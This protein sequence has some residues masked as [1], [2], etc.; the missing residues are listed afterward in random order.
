M[1][2]LI[3]AA[4]MGHFEVT[5]VLI[6][7]GASIEA[8]DRVSKILSIFSYICVCVCREDYSSII[9][10]DM[11]MSLLWIIHYNDDNSFGVCFND[12]Y[13]SASFISY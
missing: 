6:D 2:A 9:L 4:Y 10:Y 8:K 13:F 12:N 11:I 7:A 1:P 3:Y 5:K